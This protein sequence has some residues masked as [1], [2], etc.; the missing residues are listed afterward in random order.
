MMKLCECGCDK[1]VAYGHNRFITGHNT[2][3]SKQS[4][5]TILKRKQ[6]NIKK[7]GGNAPLCS[8]EIQ[9]KIKNTCIEKYG[10]DNVFKSQCPW[11]QAPWLE[12]GSEFRSNSALN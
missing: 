3:N 5:E 11:R 6:T 8:K 2:L 10:V 9:E 1:E 7:F 4:N 12:T